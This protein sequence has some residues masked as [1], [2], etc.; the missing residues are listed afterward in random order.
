MSMALLSALQ[1][2]GI[3]AAYVI[4]VLLLPWLFLRRQLAGFACVPVRFM[5]YFLIGNFYIINLVYLLQLLHISCQVTLFFGTLAPFMVR[6]VRKHRG[7][8]AEHLEKRLRRIL[9]VLGGETGRKTLLL[10]MQK[11]MGRFFIAISRKCRQSVKQFG[12][13]IVFVSG[14]IVLLV[15]MYGTNALHV[16]GYCASD[17]VLHNYWINEMGHNHIF[18]DGVYPFGMHCL[19]YYLHGVFRIPVYVLLRLFYVVQTLMIHL[20]LLAFLRSVCKSK[21]APYIGIMIYIVSD[22]FYQYT[23]IRYHATLPQ[24]LGMVFILPAA[25]FAMAFLQEKNL[26]C[27]F[28]WGKRRSTEEAVSGESLNPGTGNAAELSE[29]SQVA[30]TGGGSAAERWTVSGLYLALFAISVSLTFTVHFYDTLITGLFCLSIGVGFCF[31]VFRRE[32]LKRIVAAGLLGLLLAILPMGAAFVTGTPLQASLNWG[33][34]QWQSSSSGGMQARN[35]SEKKEERPAVLET[36]LDRMDY[37]VTND[38]ETAQVIVGSIGLLFVLGILWILFRK[39]EY[40]AILVSVS[41]YMAVMAVFQAA[42]ELGIIQILEVSRYS[43]Y[44]GYGIPVVWSLCV[45]G[46]LFLLF[47]K[48]AVLHFCSLAGFAAACVMTVKTGVRAPVCVSAYETNEAITCLENIIQENKGKTWTICSANDERQMIEEYDL[49]YHYESIKFLRDMRSIDEDTRITIP[50]STVYFFIEKVPLLYRDYINMEKPEKSISQKGAEEP[51]PKEPGILPYIGDARWI[52][53]SHLY[54]WAQ[55]FREL[56]PNEM[57]VYY[58]SDQFVCYRVKQ[59]EYSLYNFAI[60]YGYNGS[61]GTKKEQER[62][63]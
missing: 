48:T 15:Y 2:C 43:V 27:Q 31:R 41:V 10:R 5:I 20:M 62:G 53:M 59:N 37:Y 30:E 46:V 52:T 11:R 17:M 23:Y 32:Y 56:Y 49:A 36:I 57:E 1:L 12:L 14:L 38:M 34:N 18:A 33:L 50:T 39:A 3:A 35:E 21:Y 7:S 63:L 55:A 22:R 16:Y 25:Y 40:G 45:D 24:E 19:L 44:L 29:V 51:I 58:E 26:A 54:A 6:A 8:F 61:G 28:A 9:L 13:E 42:V 4:V 47:R 60:D